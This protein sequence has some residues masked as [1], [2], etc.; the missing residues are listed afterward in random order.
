MYEKKRTTNIKS[1]RLM[2]LPKNEMLIIVNYVNLKRTKATN[3][4]CHKTSFIQTVKIPTVFFV[5]RQ[6]KGPFDTVKAP[7]K[8]RLQG[9]HLQ[10]DLCLV[11]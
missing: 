3:I 4:S 7:F 8:S 6:N 5:L 11:F 9:L 10:A 1:L 2:P